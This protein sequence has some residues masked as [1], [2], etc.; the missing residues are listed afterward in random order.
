MLCTND[1]DDWRWMVEVHLQHL[2]TQP[3]RLFVLRGNEDS[4]LSIDVYDS[5]EPNAD[6]AFDRYTPNEDGDFTAA[7]RRCGPEDAI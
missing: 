6:E 5:A 7:C 1:R 2:K 3:P 4:P